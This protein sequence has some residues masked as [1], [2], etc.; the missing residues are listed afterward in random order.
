MPKPIRMPPAIFPVIL[1]LLGLGLAMRRALADLGWPGGLAEVVLGAAGALWL[2]AAAALCRKYARRP[3]AITDDLQAVPGRGGI[4]AASAGGMAC[5]AAMAPFAPQVAG[6]LLMLALVVHAGQA[7][8]LVRVLRR[9]PAPARGPNP[10]LHLSFVGPIV[11]AVA[12]L[13]LGW[14]GLATAIFWATLPV[15]MLIWAQ[16]AMQAARA[17][18]A[19]PLRPLLAIHLA[20]ASLLA[21]VAAQTGQPAVAVLLTLAGSL[22]L[23]ALVLVSRWLLAGGFSATWGSLTFPLVAY[24]GA[25]LAVGW[26]WAGLVVLLAALVVVP[27]IANRLI[28]MWADGSLAQNTGSATA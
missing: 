27:A 28:R 8:V 4:A 7:V 18:P 24:A 1:G 16:G 11:G 10:T 9:V 14:G 2:V 23:I 25:L 17:T 21:T 26:L 12:A 6:G 3:A 15:A 5:A 20:P 13:A 19:V 22:Y